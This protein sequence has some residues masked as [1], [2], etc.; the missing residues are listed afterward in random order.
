MPPVGRLVSVRRP[1]VGR[2]RRVPERAGLALPRAAGGLPHPHH[3]VPRGNPEEALGPQHAGPLRRQRTVHEPLRVEGPLGE[4]HK[5]ADA[6]A[7]SLGLPVAVVL[8]VA[9][10]VAVGFVAVGMRVAVA[11]VPAVG[12]AARCAAAGGRVA[13]L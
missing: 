9:V 12:V 5:A 4:V 6:V 2:Q 3:I 7:L 13:L 1:L 8:P 10:A 11:G